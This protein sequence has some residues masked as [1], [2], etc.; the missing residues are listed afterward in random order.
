MFHLVRK[1]LRVKI[2][3][4]LIVLVTLIMGVTIYMNIHSQ[5]KTLFEKAHEFG[6]DIARLTYASIKRP[7]ARGNS[8]MVEKQLMYIKE[9]M[10]GVEA[11]ICDF[12][13]NIVYA[14]QPKAINLSLSKFIFNEKAIKQLEKMLETGHAPSMAFEEKIGKQPGLTV[15]LPILNEKGCY[16]CHGSSKKVLGALVV[17]QSIAGIYNT[18]HSLRNQNLLIGVMGILA[19]ILLG[20]FFSVKWISRP[21]R[22][23][24][25]K[26]ARVAK[27]DFSVSMTTDREDSIGILIK[28]F[29]IMTKKIKDQIEYANSLKFSIS[30]PFFITDPN[31]T[32]TYM[33]KALEKLTGYSKSEVEGKKKCYEIIKSDFCETDCFFKKAV[34]SGETIIGKRGIVRQM[35]GKEVPVITSGAPL[36]DST[37]KIW[38]GFHFIRDI[39]ME[40][41]AEKTI[42]EAAAREEAQRL[43]LEK[44]VE[45]L[46]ELFGKIAKGDLTRRAEIE[47]KEDMMDTLA[48]HVNQM[49]DNISNIIQQA[50]EEALAVAER[51]SEI[52]ANNQDLSERTQKQA[53]S[54]EEVSASIQEMTAIINQNAKNTAKVNELAKWAVDAAK[55][56]GKVAGDAISSMERIKETSNRITEIVNLVNDITFQTKLLSLNAAVEAAR[57]G[58]QGKGFA[59]IAAEIKDLAIRSTEAAKDI[60]ALIEESAVKVGEGINFVNSTSENLQKI[61]G[62]ITKVSDVIAEITSASG[63]QTEGIEQINKT[64]MEINKVIQQNAAFVEELASAS[65]KLADEAEVLLE[66]T[67]GFITSEMSTKETQPRSLPEELVKKAEPK[68][69]M[70]SG[71]PDLDLEDKFEEF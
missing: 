17:K 1:Y 19:L 36:K 35:D 56:G 40:V 9:S 32:V 15:L 71:P 62:H 37:G 54:V 61:I 33:N 66:L 27:G 29:N 43:Y 11:Y 63:Q 46:V 2:L 16:H 55:E 8:E 48:Q 42:K 20:S 47:G 13:K 44:R 30:E 64:V 10:E 50:K 52:S 12:N 67:R 59:V 26:T 7:M 24:A 31:F 49:L 22:E 28:N 51:A 4:A 6:L 23:L 21:T 38:G 45:K 57:A 3:L 65:E 34:Q 18:I 5:E 41:E 14:S 69:E 70:G 53:V 58:E 60:Q 39:T 25:E 68:E